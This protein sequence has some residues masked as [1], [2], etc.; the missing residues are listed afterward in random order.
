MAFRTRMAALV[1]SL[2]NNYQTSFDCACVAHNLAQIIAVDVQPR[3][4]TYNQSETD[5]IQYMHSTS[6]ETDHCSC[7]MGER[8]SVAP[9]PSHGG[10]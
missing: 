7:Y 9:G 10:T 4:K 6:A 5:L 2:L 1:L 3:L 8:L